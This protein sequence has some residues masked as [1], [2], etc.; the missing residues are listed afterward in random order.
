MQIFYAVFK[1]CSGSIEIARFS[2]LQLPSLYFDTHRLGTPNKSMDYQA[3]IFTVE[4]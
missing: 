1:Y 2:Y 3:T 4:H